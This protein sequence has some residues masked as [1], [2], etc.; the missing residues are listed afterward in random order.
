MDQFAAVL[1]QL[2]TFGEALDASF[3]ALE[4]AST[5][6]FGA[7]SEVSGILDTI[8]DASSDLT[9]SIPGS[10]D[11]VEQIVKLIP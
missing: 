10:V 7:S 2:G 4:S 8:T 5:A 11:F 9:G 3:G 6:A 1:E